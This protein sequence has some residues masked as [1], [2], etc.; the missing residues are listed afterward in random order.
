MMHFFQYFSLHN[1]YYRKSTVEEEDTT[2]YIVS[3][4]SIELS[5]FI[6]LLFNR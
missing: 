3:S 2:S 5:L 6:H 1:I 4:S